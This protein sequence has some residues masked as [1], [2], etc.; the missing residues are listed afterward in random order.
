MREKIFVCRQ[1]K[2]FAVHFIDLICYND[3]DQ[4]CAAEK[5]TG[6]RASLNQYLFLPTEAILTFKYK[7]FSFQAMNSDKKFFLP[8]SPTHVAYFQF[9]AGSFC[10]TL[11]QLY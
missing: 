2:L 3:I 11:L 4:R 1:S 6:R 9:L 7:T 10:L 8:I 5:F